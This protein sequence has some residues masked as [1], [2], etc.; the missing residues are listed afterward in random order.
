MA[1]AWSDRVTNLISLG[2]GILS[3]GFFSVVTIISTL[4]PDYF[5]RPL[6]DQMI[7]GSTEKP[8]ATVEGAIPVPKLVRSAALTPRD[9]Q[10][11]MVF[12]AEAHLASPGE[13]WRV[14]VGSLVPGLGE[15]LEIE[16]GENGGTVRAENATL[17]GV[18]N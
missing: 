12:G 7:T 4:D 14:R 17:T 1:T 15:I 11:V 10:I 18:R 16:P 5:D 3:I 9:F 8:D 2:L 6:L 13:L